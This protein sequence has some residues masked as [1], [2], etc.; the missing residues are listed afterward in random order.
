MIKKGRFT[1]NKIIDEATN[2]VTVGT[3]IEKTSGSYIEVLLCIESRELLIFD[4]VQSGEI[5]DNFKVYAGKTVNE[6]LSMNGVS[7]PTWTE[8]LAQIS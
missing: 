4:N 3:V 1:Q 6:V 8:E 5:N 7:N 2:E